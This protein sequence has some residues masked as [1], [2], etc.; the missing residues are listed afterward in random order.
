VFIEKWPKNIKPFYMKIDPS[1][2]KHV[3]NND[4]I[5]TDGGGEIIGGS[6][7][8]ESVEVL[9]ARMKEENL[10]IKDYQWYLDI[11]RYGSVP[12]SGFGIG[13]ERTVR[14]ITGVEHIRECIPF[15][16]TISRLRP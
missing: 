1:D 10:P 14:W 4:L 9:E 15:P 8:E 12:H 16:R 2:P 13:L 5:A 7:R 3:L 11:R 6:E